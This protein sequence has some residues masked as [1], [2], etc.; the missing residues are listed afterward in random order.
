MLLHDIDHIFNEILKEEYYEPIEIKSAFDS[1]YI[2][3]ESK[4]YNHDNL[5]LEDYLIIIGPYL[6]DMINNKK[7]HGKWKIQLV[8]RI[9]FVSSSNTSELREMHTKSNNIRVVLKL[10]MLLMKFLN[11]F[12]NDIRKD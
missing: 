8:M 7:A 3:Y 12:L 5:S 4:G 1:D 10:M 6:E 2:K 9:I 11:L